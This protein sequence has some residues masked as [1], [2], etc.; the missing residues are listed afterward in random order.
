MRTNQLWAMLLLL[1]VRQVTASPRIHRPN[2]PV[3]LVG[4]STDR[5]NAIAAAA[6][7]SPPA[8]GAG[9]GA[10]SQQS[11]SG[12]NANS[13]FTALAAAERELSD[14]QAALRKTP[15]SEALEGSIRRVTIARLRVTTLWWLIRNTPFTWPPIPANATPQTLAA[16]ATLAKFRNRSDLLL[17]GSIWARDRGGPPVDGRVVEWRMFSWL[18][19]FREDN[20]EAVLEQREWSLESEFSSRLNLY[21]NNASAL[22]RARTPSQRNRASSLMGTFWEMMVAIGRVEGSLAFMR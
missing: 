22:K 5:A 3:R 20:C 4:L 13:L 10:S 21:V 16:D 15:D 6:S 2:D 14:A 8:A 19:S 18:A 17:R 9:G 12:A 1:S 7:S 11:P